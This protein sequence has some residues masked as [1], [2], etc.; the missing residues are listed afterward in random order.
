VGL[1]SFKQC[2]RL[3]V[4]LVAALTGAGKALMV[5]GGGNFV[6]QMPMTAH[7]RHLSTGLWAP[8][9]EVFG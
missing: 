6:T 5:I 7:A 3:Y 9:T 2:W 4:R 8:S 1:P